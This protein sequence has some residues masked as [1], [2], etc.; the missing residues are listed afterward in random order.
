MALAEVGNRFALLSFVGELVI[1]REVAAG[2]V[3]DDHAR[4]QLLARVDVRECVR[5]LRGVL[6]V[7]TLPGSVPTGGAEARVGVDA[8]DASGTVHTRVRRALVKILLAQRANPARHALARELYLTG[9]IG[10]FTLRAGTALLARVGLALLQIGARLAAV[11][12][13][14]TEVADT[15]V[16]GCADVEAACLVAI[17]I[18]FIT[19][20]GI[21]LL[22]ADDT[23]PALC[24][25]ARIS[26]R[27]V[28]ARGSVRARRRLTVVRVKLAVV[29]V[30][31]VSAHARVRENV[32]EASSGMLTG[33]R[34]ALIELRP[35][36]AR[37][38]VHVTGSASARVRVHAVVTGGTVQ[39]RLGAA[40]INIR[41][42]VGA[43]VAGDTSACVVV[44]G[45]ALACTRVS[46]SGTV[47]AR[48][49]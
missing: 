31:A 47:L 33:A 9:L 49:R 8:I 7:G 17:A 29:A 19:G 42:A 14:V 6:H 11:S 30:P 2:S 22:R 27:L 1:T 3:P 34:G 37:R 28:N 48:A 23:S 12:C 39:A 36:C 32:V 24:T 44:R 4:V 18:V 13:F 16:P 15:L 43:R 45:D 20:A 46:A 35:A 5:D 41:R 38:G 40:L 10:A 21:N 25:S 26:A